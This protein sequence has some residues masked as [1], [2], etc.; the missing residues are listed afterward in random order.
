[1]NRILARQGQTKQIWKR[2]KEMKRNLTLIY[3]QE[4][5]VLTLLSGTT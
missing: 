5:A 1:M 4:N 3:K 2:T